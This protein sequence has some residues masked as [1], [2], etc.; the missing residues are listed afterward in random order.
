M[1]QLSNST[2]PYSRVRQVATDR[3]GQTGTSF[4]EGHRHLG[5]PP[6]TFGGLA[7]RQKIYQ[8]RMTQKVP[9]GRNVTRKRSLVRKVKAHVAITLLSPI[10]SKEPR[11]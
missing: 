5:V 8:G 10:A 11:R 7:P 9:G 4:G 3:R 2:S 1:V 6:D